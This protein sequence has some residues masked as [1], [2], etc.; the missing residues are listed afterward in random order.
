MRDN[1]LYLKDILEAMQAIEEFV[2]KMDFKEFENSDLVSSAVIRKFEIMGEA[3]KN[4]PRD[5]VQDNPEIPWRRMAGMRDRLIHFYF[6]VKYD[7]IWQTIKKEIPY[8]KPL[9]QKILEEQE[10]KR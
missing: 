4:I 1:K 9:I 5:L 7:L 3:V 10:Q 6:G 2:E 8:L